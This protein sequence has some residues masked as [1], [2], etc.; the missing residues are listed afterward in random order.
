MVLC[1]VF[2][3]QGNQIHAMAHRT[4]KENGRLVMFLQKLGIFQGRKMHGWHH[5]APYDTNFFI[6]TNYLNPI[7]NKIKFFERLEWLILKIL[8]I[9]PLRGAQIRGGV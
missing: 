4:N 2:S 3:T 7:F 8:R 6:L 1:L 9:K 5:R